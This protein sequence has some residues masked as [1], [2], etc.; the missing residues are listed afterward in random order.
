M[1]FERI[2]DREAWDKHIKE[3]VDHPVND[4]DDFSHYDEGGNMI[5]EPPFYPIEVHSEWPEDSKECYLQ[6]FFKR[7][8]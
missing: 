7:I 3:V 6:H 2:E 5:T 8:K 4:V 1:I